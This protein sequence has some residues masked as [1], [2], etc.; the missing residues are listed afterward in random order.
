MLT[1][2]TCSNAFALKNDYKILVHLKELK[3]DLNLLIQLIIKLTEYN[4]KHR[5][6]Y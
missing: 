4:N 3:F 5:T 6:L 1:N 2:E